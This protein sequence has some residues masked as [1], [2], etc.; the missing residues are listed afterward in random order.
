MAA[1]LET[2][3]RAGDA[4]R[5]KAKA[6]PMP[7]YMRLRELL[8]TA[9]ERGDYE[10]RRLPTD[11]ELTERFG[12][13][14]HTVRQAMSELAAE[15]LIRR[16]PGRG[17]FATGAH[18][19]KYVR[20]FGNVSDLMAMATDTTLKVVEALHE[21]RD[22][23]AARKLGLT[24]AHVATM[25]I[26]RFRQGPPL[27]VSR[28]FLPPHVAARVEPLSTVVDHHATVLERVMRYAGDVAIEAEQEITAVPAEDATAQLLEVTPGEALLRIERLYRLESGE[29]VELAISHYRPDRYTYRVVLRGKGGW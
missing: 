26:V 21:V 16:E 24:E 1:E 2:D 20:A 15:G 7:T 29:P 3:G 6:S 4:P 18:N 17:T 10:Q 14:R 8:R 9:I 23:D 19:S 28:V 25:L 22:A 11:S 13:S 27:S 5:S 12:V